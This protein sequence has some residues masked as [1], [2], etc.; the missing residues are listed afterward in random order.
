MWAIA[1]NETYRHFW[2]YEISDE[3]G[4][5][6]EYGKVALFENYKT[7]Y[8]FMIENTDS[9]AYD[10]YVIEL[11]EEEL[12]SIADKDKFEVLRNWL[13]ENVSNEKKEQ[14]NKLLENLQ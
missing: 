6:K 13:E 1:F 11:T 12:R 5:F 2:R 14:I 9:R 3:K 7:A 4:D 8:K 10:F